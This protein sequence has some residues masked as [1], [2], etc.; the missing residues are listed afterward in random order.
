MRVFQSD[1]QTW[2]AQTPIFASKMRDLFWSSIWRSRICVTLPRPKNRFLTLRW[3][4]NS[5]FL[6]SYRDVLLV[7]TSNMYMTCWCACKSSHWA[8]CFDFQTMCTCLWTSE[9]PLPCHPFLMQKGRKFFSA[10]A[11]PLLKVIWFWSEVSR[12]RTQD[13]YLTTTEWHCLIPQS[14]S[15]Y[16][17][18]HCV[19]HSVH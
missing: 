13:R 16:S 12:T 6:F 2:E 1:L 10:G 9:K 8:Q 15:G 18:H 11:W 7:Q 5:N 4:S 19:S 3:G 17:I 14:R